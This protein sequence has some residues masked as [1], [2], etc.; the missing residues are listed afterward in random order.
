MST[1]TRDDVLTWYTPTYLSY[2]TYRPWRTMFFNYEYKNLIA[3]VQ[4]EIDNLQTLI[5]DLQDIS[6]KDANS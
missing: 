2:D 3:S 6:K 5:Y 4:I 1:T